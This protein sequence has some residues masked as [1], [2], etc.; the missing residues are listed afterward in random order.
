MPA[1]WKLYSSMCF[2]WNRYLCLYSNITMVLFW[3]FD[4]SVVNLVPGYGRI[5]K[6]DK[7]FIY[8]TFAALLFPVLVS[9]CLLLL[10]LI[11]LYI[12]QVTESHWSVHD[13]LM[14]SG[15]WQQDILAWMCACVCVIC[16]T[17]V[18]NLIP[19]CILLHDCS[20]KDAP[21]C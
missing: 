11:S 6:Q 9:F 12:R 3:M 18:K 1:G 16:V 15:W 2:M 5:D 10:T 7:S 13:F 4:N 19:H 21:G 14:K 17:A 8:W 20:A